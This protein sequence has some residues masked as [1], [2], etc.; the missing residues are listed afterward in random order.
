MGFARCAR[1]IGA[2]WVRVFCVEGVV[3]VE[4]R[5]RRAT[6]DEEKRKFWGAEEATRRRGWALLLEL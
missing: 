1:K 5:R 6:G 3:L 2:C 4:E